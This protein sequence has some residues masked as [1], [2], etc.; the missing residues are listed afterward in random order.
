M[1]TKK[2]VMIGAVAVGGFF[3]YTKVIAPR[4]AGPAKTSA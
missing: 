1:T 2:L 3:L 4:L